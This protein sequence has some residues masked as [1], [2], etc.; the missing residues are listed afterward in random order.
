LRLGIP[1][2]TFRS[3]EWSVTDRTIAYIQ[4]HCQPL[5]RQ[6]N[7]EIRGTGANAGPGVLYAARSG[8]TCK[9]GSYLSHQRASL[10]T[11][12]SQRRQPS[13]GTYSR[14]NRVE[15]HVRGPVPDGGFERMGCRCHRGYSNRHTART[16]MFVQLSGRHDTRSVRGAALRRS[17]ARHSRKSRC[18]R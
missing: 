14:H 15:H 17:D 13:A 8:R 18:A 6:G 1:K 16:F 7:P 4:S 11:H 12:R 2:S 5:L 3:R 9:S 10:Q